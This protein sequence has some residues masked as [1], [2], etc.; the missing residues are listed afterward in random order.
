[1]FAL[2]PEQRVREEES[3]KELERKRLWGEG[4]AGILG[5]IKFSNQNS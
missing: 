1:V 3:M 4:G 5:E 2:E